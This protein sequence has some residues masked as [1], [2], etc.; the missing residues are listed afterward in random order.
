VTASAKFSYSE[1]VLFIRHQNVED[2]S[3]KNLLY[4][5]VLPLEFLLVP[6]AIFTTIL[7]GIVLGW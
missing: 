2:G 1:N 4:L 5:A 7:Y 3:V 6:A